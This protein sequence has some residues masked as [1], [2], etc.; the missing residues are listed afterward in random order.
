MATRFSFIEGMTRLA[1]PWLRRKVGA[2]VLKG[3]GEAIEVQLDR[4][5]EGIKKRFPDANSL[6]A[7]DLLGRERRILRGPD[8]PATSFAER[9]I[10]WWDSHLLRGG[11]YALLTQT[12]EFFKDTDNLPIDLINNSGSAYRID[13]AGVITRAPIDGWTGDGNLPEK[14]ARIFLLFELSSGSVVED[15]W[16]TESGDNMVTESGD[17]LVVSSSPLVLSQAEKDVFCSVPLEWRA[18]HID[19]IFI[20]LLP[21]GGVVFGFPP[22]QFGDAGL[23][24]GGGDGLL[25]ECL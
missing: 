1:P 5:I 17:N 4:T 9:L 19:K 7:L 13:T 11:P 25:F 23:T 8:E 21:P 3:A 10:L 22:A 14:W 15:N 20:I 24:F 2:A 6:E 18:G 12:H 16:I